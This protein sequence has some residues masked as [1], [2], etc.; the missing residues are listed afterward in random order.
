[1][2]NGET[3]GDMLRRSG[4]RAHMKDDDDATSTSST[5]SNTP[6][7]YKETT[8]RIFKRKTTGRKPHGSSRASSRA[9]SVCDEPVSLH[10]TV[11]TQ[12]YDGRQSPLRSGTSDLMS[13]SRA[14]LLHQDPPGLSSGYSSSEDVYYQPSVSS[15][16]SVFAF[17]G[18]S[19][20][21]AEA[22]FDL[23]DALVSP[24]RSMQT[25]YWWLGS[26]WYS[27]TSGISLLDVFL[28]SRWTA[29]VRKTAL[30]LILLLVLGLWL[31]FITASSHKASPTAAW[32]RQ[33]EQPSVDTAIIHAGSLDALRDEIL[34]GLNLHKAK[35]N[36]GAARELGNLRREIYLLKQDELKQ[37]HMTE[38][39]HTDLKDLHL[40]MK[41]VQSEHQSLLDKNVAGIKQQVMEM[42]TDLSDLRK[43]TELLQTRIE[44]QEFN[45][46]KNVIALKTELSSWL[47]EKL[48]SNHLAPSLE[49]AVLRPE[50]QEALEALEKRLLQQLGQDAWK[51]VGETLQ[52]EGAGSIT[53]KDMEQ[54]VHRALSLYRADGTGMADFAL[55]SSGASV[56]NTRC[57]ETYRT[58]SAC[59]SLFGFPL[60]YHSESPRT[61][62]QPELYPGKCWAFQGAEGF[63]VIALS[64]P[65]HI[66]HVTLEHLPRVLSPTGRIDSAPRDFSVYGLNSETEEGSHVGTFIYDQNGEPIQTFRLP[67]PMENFYQMVEL[68]ILSNWGHPEYTCVYRF[69]V[70]GEAMVTA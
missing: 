60:W 15:K 12:K 18:S 13:S 20:P 4:R 34:T 68:R 9:S 67:V 30:L 54:I 47:L 56:I 36:G 59:I 49:E 63:L 61:V 64:Y 45:D 21:A 2:S 66:T 5:G 27:L 40:K 17:A 35:W 29:S 33:G 62:I 65:V 51:S 23:R 52:R 22:E 3:D 32:E 1:M 38:M 16:I 19:Q 28:L 42:S 41:I 39:L 31:W 8:V 70:H 24:V 55:E 6:V 14:K 50:L 46:A 44:S 43:T 37:K 58:R 11:Q 57:S 48:S 53:I 10:K 25:L 69:R 26:A 7:T